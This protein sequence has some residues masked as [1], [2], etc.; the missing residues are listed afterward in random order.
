MDEERV[1]G[2]EGERA[3]GGQCSDKGV[4]TDTSTMVRVSFLIIKLELTY[5]LE[6]KHTKYFQKVNEF[7]IFHPK[8]LRKIVVD[9]LAEKHM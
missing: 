6:N 4:V 8:Y 3:G 7:K 5:I 2:R 9:T 1:V